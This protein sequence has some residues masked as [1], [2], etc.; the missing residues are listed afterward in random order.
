M[1]TLAAYRAL[2]GNRNLL[3]FFTGEFISGIGDWLYLV[4]LLVIVYRETNDPLLLGIVGGARIIPYIVLSVPAGVIVDRF[5]RRLILIVT[6]LIRAAAMVGMALVAWLDGPVLLIIGLAI[7]ATCFAV[8]FRPSLGA[9]LPS[10]VKDEAQLGPANSAFA[11]L[12]ELS[13]IVGPAIGGILIA[14]T[15]LALAFAINAVTFIVAD[16][17]LWTLPANRPGDKAAASAEAA[18]SEPAATDREP[19]TAPASA[20]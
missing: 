8:F 12:G 20:A 9:Y 19:A 16:I 18:P 1:G 10:L 17:V 3:R 6:D 14:A 15:D 13:F 5:D 7:F 4:A 11:T 2:I